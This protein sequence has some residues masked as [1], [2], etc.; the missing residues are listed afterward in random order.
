[1]ITYATL[2]QFR[3]RLG[4]PAGDAE[5]D[6]RLLVALRQA[7]AQ[8]DRFTARRFAPVVQTRR[9]AFYDPH[10][11]RLDLDLLELLAITNG[12]GQAIPP[13]VAL[14]LPDG[15][16]PRHAILLQPAAGVWFVPGE[17]PAAAIAVR[18]I[19][20]THDAWSEAWRAAGDALAAAL[21]AAAGQVAVSDA[22]GPDAA[23]VAP[24]FQAGQLLRL[25]DEYL[26]VTAVDPVTDMLSVIRGVRGT[27]AAS[28]AGGTALEIYV[29]PEDVTALCLRWAA[30]LYQQADAAIGAGADWLYPPD[31]PDDLRRL[32]AP[33]RY[34][35]VA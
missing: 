26:H 31:L 12:D 6:A 10:S 27:T 29:P 22:D 24:R 7:T 32:A 34:I 17:N 20:G 11:L 3:A 5:T 18:G 9:Y 35:R 8:I 4:L 14:L 15:D 21:D 16:G 33:L 25:D 2:T 30:W 19:W 1:M 23:G 13:E 28:H